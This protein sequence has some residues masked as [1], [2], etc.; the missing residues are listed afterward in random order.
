MKRK[1]ATAAN[2]PSSSTF[3]CVVKR[4][5]GVGVILSLLLG[6][7]QAAKLV[8]DARDRMARVDEMVRVAQVQSD[9]DEP[10]EAWAGLTRAI[11]LIDEAGPLE[12]SLWAVQRRRRTMQI[13][14]QDGDAVVA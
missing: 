7:F 3:E 6:L 2:V 1:P 4:V 10:A 14:Q 13:Q 8:H 9:R 12:S 5:A 11:A